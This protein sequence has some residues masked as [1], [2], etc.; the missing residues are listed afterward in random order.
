MKR[1]GFTLIEV[2]V[3]IAIIAILVALLLPAV[4]AVREASRRCQCVNNLMQ[5]GIALENYDTAHNVLPPGVVNDTGPIENLPNGYHFGWLTQILPFLDRKNVAAHIDQRVSVYAPE[6]LTWR[7]VEINTLLCPS[8]PFPK[9]AADGV[10]ETNY[11]AVHD[12]VER[13]IDVT[14][15]GVFFLN[16]RVRVED[17][18]DGTSQT[19]F[20][21]EK[22]IDVPALGWASG[23]RA[24]LRNTGTQPNSVQRGAGGVPAPDLDDV[25]ETGM[26]LLPNLDPV[27][28][29]SSRHPGGA[30]FLMG[31]GSVRF[32]KNSISRAVFRWLGQRNDEEVLDANN[33]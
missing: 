18:T 31:D 29:F 33:W 15:R 3:V 20:A 19:V 17:V 14:N 25:D 23:T 11:A 8:D 32:L 12:G 24:S 27:G 1:H 4:Q 7:Q 10:I 16:S 2:L 21:G 30:N 26:P 22:V 28:G 13:P 9:R 5:I 6:N